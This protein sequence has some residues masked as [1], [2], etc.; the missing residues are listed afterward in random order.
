MKERTIYHGL[1]IYYLKEKSRLFE[2]VTGIKLITD[3]DLREIND[4]SINKIKKV[5]DNICD[6]DK[7]GD[8]KACPWCVYY[9]NKCSKCGY[10]RR[11][12][13]CINDRTSINF[14]SIYGKI[15]TRLLDLDLIEYTY[16]IC[17]YDKIILLIDHVKQ[18]YRKISDEGFLYSDL[19]YLESFIA[20]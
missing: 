14:E 20:K 5:F 2:Q 18:C 6:S 8:K 19:F 13:T 17:R 7:V 3:I 11:H 12:G 9:Y 10:G 15:H 4:W 16:G 1:M